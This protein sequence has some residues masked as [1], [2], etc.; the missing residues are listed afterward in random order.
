[1][2]PQG[3]SLK[4]SND[5]IGNR[6]RD[7]PVCSI[8]HLSFRSQDMTAGRASLKK[9]NWKCCGSHLGECVAAKCVALMQHP[10]VMAPYSFIINHN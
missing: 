10:G 9:K 5:T 1:V 6:T 3:L 7:L 2:R 4:N 8:L